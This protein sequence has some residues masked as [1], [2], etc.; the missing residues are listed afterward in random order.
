MYMK[1][2]A[3]AM[4]KRVKAEGKEALLDDGVLEVIGQGA[5]EIG[6]D[7]NWDECVYGRDVVWIPGEQLP[8]ED[9]DGTY[10]ARCDCKYI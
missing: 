7:N 3:D 6:R 10:V 1:F 8:D 5:G 2:S 9:F 4:L